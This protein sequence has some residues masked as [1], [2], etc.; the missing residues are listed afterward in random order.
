MIVDFDKSFSKSLLRIKDQSILVRVKKC[1]LDLENAENLTNVKN[2]RKLSGF[3][4]YFRIRI[5]DY[6]LGLEL[7]E[8]KRVRLIVILHRKDIYKS[9]P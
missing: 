5:G 7:N 6:R 3:K 8:S 4:T 2:I 9:F 1:I